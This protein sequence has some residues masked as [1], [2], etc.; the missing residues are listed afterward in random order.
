MAWL[1]LSI[2]TRAIRI[3][4]PVIYGILFAIALAADS[5]ILI[6]VTAL[7]SMPI[8]AFFLIYNNRNIFTSVKERSRFIHSAST[9]LAVNYIAIISIVLGAASI[10][11][12]LVPIF[13]LKSVPIYNYPY[14]IFLVFSSFSPVLFVALVFCVPA[15]L[16]IVKFL[17]RI[18]KIDKKWFSQSLISEEKMVRGRSKKTIIIY[19][20]LIVLHYLFLINRLTFFCLCPSSPSTNS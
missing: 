15:K 11:S 17:V 2:K 20:S 1:V 9:Y 19:F 14:A 16:F 3:S 5:D 7:I 6:D 13:F 12:Y 4:I 10:F 18:F 8:I